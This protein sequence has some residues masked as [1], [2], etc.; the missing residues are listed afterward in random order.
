MHAGGHILPKF[1]KQ[2]FRMNECI[3][4]SLSFDLLVVDLR[5]HAVV[6]QALI[7]SVSPTHISQ[8]LCIL[9]TS[10]LQLKDQGLYIN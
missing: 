9:T 5:I 10:G 8:L 7:E 1:V 3:A 4:S 6:K 2:F